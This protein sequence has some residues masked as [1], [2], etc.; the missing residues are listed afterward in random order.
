MLPRVSGNGREPAAMKFRKVRIFYNRR[1]GP[2]VSRF[3]RIE[4]AFAREWAGV[5]DDLAWYFPDSPERSRA[6]L[7]A[8]LADGADLVVVCGGD[9]TVAS[10]GAELV[11]RGVPMGVVPLGSG[12]GLARHFNQNLDPVASVAQLARGTVR[13]MDVGRVAGR[14]FLTSASVAWDAALVRA[15]DQMPMRGVGSYVLAGAVSFFEYV[16]QPL[17]ATV[18]GGE[19]FEMDDPLLFTVGNVA[20]WGGGALID[21]SADAGDGRMELVAGRRKDAARMLADLPAVFS[22]GSCNLPGVVHRS[23]STLRVERAEARPIQLDGELVDVPATLDFTVEPR[24]LP[25]LVPDFP[26]NGPRTGF[27][28]AGSGSSSPKIAIVCA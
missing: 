24:R 18:D 21:P 15:Y 17:R 6:M 28:R 10:I 7:R 13:D 19:T 25:L 12:N 3:H 20:G 16:P 8:A 2:G 26:S 23:F 4:E 27:Y 9:G 1:S 14:V 11:G 5:A 22:A